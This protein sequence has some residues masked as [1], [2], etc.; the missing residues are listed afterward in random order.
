MHLDITVTIK[1]YENGRRD[2]RRLYA[3]AGMRY[4]IRKRNERVWLAYLHV[5]QR[6]T[7]YH[8]IQSLLQQSVFASQPHLSE[9]LS[10]PLEEAPIPSDYLEITDYIQL[11]F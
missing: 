4:A 2:R 5:H 6:P 10:H 11:M 7:P 8:R 1:S 9:H 3:F